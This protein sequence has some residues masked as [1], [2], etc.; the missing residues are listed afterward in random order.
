MFIYESMSFSYLESSVS[1]QLYAFLTL[2]QS[3]D[4]HKEKYMIY[5]GTRSNEYRKKRG[6]KSVW[7]SNLNDIVC[8]PLP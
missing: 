3:I 7:A 2:D 8:L 1:F 4:Y 5:E 6:E